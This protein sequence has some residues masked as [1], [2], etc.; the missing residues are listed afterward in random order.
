[1]SE[2]VRRKTA[3]VL[4]GSAMVNVTVDTPAARF[5]AVVAYPIGSTPAIPIL[6]LRT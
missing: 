2:T 5:S 4:V 3:A 1:M 6:P